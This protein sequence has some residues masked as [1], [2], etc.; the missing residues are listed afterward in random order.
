[1]TKS[2]VY[3]YDSETSTYITVYYDNPKIFGDKIKQLRKEK[4]L[5]VK[6][7]SDHIGWWHWCIEAWENG[8]M[9]D[10]TTLR[11]LAHFFNVS[12][13]YLL[14]NKENEQLSLF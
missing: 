5:T 1:M 11:K 7:F 3:C 2:W 4:G 9:V 6:Q 12:T 10:I 13:D 8:D 14:S